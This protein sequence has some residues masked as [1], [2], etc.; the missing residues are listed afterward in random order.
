M[1]GR[2]KQRTFELG[3]FGLSPCPGSDMTVWVTLIVGA[4]RWKLKVETE[5]WYGRDRSRGVDYITGKTG[6]ELYQNFSDDVSNLT[7][8]QFCD[9]LRQNAQVDAC[10]AEAV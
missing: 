6:L 5:E 9:M 8:E 7:R 4:R 1:A 10:I 2:T 3:D